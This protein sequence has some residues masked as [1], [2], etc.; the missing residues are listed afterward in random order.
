MN[1]SRCTVLFLLTSSIT[2]EISDHLVATTDNAIVKRDFPFYDQIAT[3]ASTANKWRSTIFWGAITHTC[4]GVAGSG[5]RAVIWCACN[6]AKGP[7]ARSSCIKAMASAAKRA[8]LAVAI[9]SEATNLS[10]SSAKRED[11]DTAMA[12]ILVIA[13]LS[14]TM[15]LEL[16]TS[17]QLL[18][19][20]LL[21][22]MVQ[23]IIFYK[24]C[25][26]I[27]LTSESL[28]GTVLM[29]VTCLMT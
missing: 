21:K 13:G 24:I 29:A 5:A 16:L 4:I 26:L 15:I 3:V 7:G 17:Q 10:G 14:I 8:T 27:I 12:E 11:V 28:T 9:T 19:L 23:M 22:K 18:V 20:V 6:D 2:A 1:F 25:Q